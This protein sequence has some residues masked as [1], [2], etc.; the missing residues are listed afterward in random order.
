MLT[1]REKRL[2]SC[3]CRLFHTSSCENN[4][5]S[6]TF[7]TVVHN[8]NHGYSLKAGVVPGVLEDFDVKRVLDFSSTS[9]TVTTVCTCRKITVHLNLATAGKHNRELRESHRTIG[10]QTGPAQKYLTTLKHFPT[11]LI[12]HVVDV[13][14]LHKLFIPRQ[15]SCKLP[16][17]CPDGTPELPALTGTV[18]TRGPARFLARKKNREPL[19]TELLSRR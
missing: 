11:F 3:Q 1:K 2:Y 12:L 16:P 10:N 5:G 15:R 19:R 6:I 18:N 13:Q 9:H 17:L 7:I 8:H 14:M 4:A